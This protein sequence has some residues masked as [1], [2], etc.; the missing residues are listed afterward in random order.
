MKRKLLFRIIACSVGATA[1]FALSSASTQAQNLLI[2]PSFENPA[3]FTVSPNG[4]F[5]GINPGWGLYNPQS[6][7]LAPEQTNMSGSPDKPEDGDYAL[8][9]QNAPGNDWNP[10]IAYQVVSPIDGIN[11]ENLFSFSIWYLSDTSFTGIFYPNVC[12]EMTFLNSSLNVIGTEENPGGYNGGFSY[13]IPDINTWYQGSIS[14]T[15]PAGAE[16]AVVIAMF[17]DDAQTT[18]ENVYFDNASLTLVPEPY[19]LALTGM[20]LTI[21]FYFFRRRKG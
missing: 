21:P 11:A 10:P 5:S 16:Y 17:M 3:G 19:S 20:G 13:A 6:T 14:G 2:N 18:T 4:S 8:L 15:A 7:S 1:A 9:E 12:I